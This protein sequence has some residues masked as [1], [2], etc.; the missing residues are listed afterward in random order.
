MDP[1]LHNVITDSL[2]WTHLFYAIGKYKVVSTPGHFVSSGAPIP[3]VRFERK[4]EER[5]KCSIFS[6]YKLN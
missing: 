6:F 2:R 3:G 1:P 5:K 4:K